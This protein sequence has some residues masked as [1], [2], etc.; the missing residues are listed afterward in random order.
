[1][2]VVGWASPREHIHVDGLG[3]LS[4]PRTAP[5]SVG[6]LVVPPPSAREVLPLLPSRG[7]A[8]QVGPVVGAAAAMQCTLSSRFSRGGGKPGLGIIDPELDT[9]GGGQIVRVRLA[10]PCVRGMAGIAAG[11]GIG[12]GGHAGDS[13]EQSLGLTGNAWGRLNARETGTGLDAGHASA[14]GSVL[15]LRRASSRP[16]N[17]GIDMGAPGGPVSLR[18]ASSVQPESVARR[19]EFP[20]ATGPL[21]R[22]PLT[23]IP[24]LG[25]AVGAADM[26]RASPQHGPVRNQG[27]TKGS[28]GVVALGGIVPSMLPLPPALLLAA[29]V[30]ARCSALDGSLCSLPSWLMAKGATAPGEQRRRVI[31]TD[32][33]QK[34]VR[35]FVQGL[36]RDLSR[37]RA[38]GAAGI[39][40]VGRGDGAWAGVETEGLAGNE[41]RIYPQ[42]R[43]AMRVLGLDAHLNPGPGPGHV[44]ES[45]KGREMGMMGLGHGGITGIGRGSGMAFMREAEA[46]MAGAKTAAAAGLVADDESILPLRASGTGAAH[47]AGVLETASY[48]TLGSDR[49]GEPTRGLTSAVL[50]VGDMVLNAPFRPAPGAKDA[51]RTSSIGGGPGCTRTQYMQSKGVR[52]GAVQ[53]LEAKAAQHGRIMLCIRALGLLPRMSQA[54]RELLYVQGESIALARCLMS[55][56]QRLDRAGASTGRGSQG[57]VLRGAVYDAATGWGYDPAGAGR[58]GVAPDELVVGHVGELGG[59]VG[60]LLGAAA[61]QAGA[62]GDFRRLCSAV[63]LVLQLG[64]AGRA[65]RARHGASYGVDVSPWG[66]RTTGIIGQSSGPAVEWVGAEAGSVAGTPLVGAFAAR[67]TAR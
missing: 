29:T 39:A 46:V 22:M 36:Q 58:A 43:D 35:A 3:G 62:A 53:L 27:T 32:A 33:I 30:P 63:R 61:E 55:V 5:P 13:K 40:G 65:F 28:T 11:F 47:D 66:T 54:G 20:T 34:T 18:R 48:R 24:F 44:R 2:A 1:M 52:P 19:V 15:L 16:G 67:D 23:P 37:G 59:V 38:R 7:V 42:V 4:P 26:Q 56:L 64:A 25:L 14:T 49:G 60:R 51:S 21:S 10:V 17:T 6:L 9:D 8:G 45:E 57:A 41:F 31:G 50:D 12:F